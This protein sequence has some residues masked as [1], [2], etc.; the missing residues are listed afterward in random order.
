MRDWLI[1]PHLPITPQEFD[2]AWRL[3]SKNTP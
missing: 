1:T 2:A 3:A